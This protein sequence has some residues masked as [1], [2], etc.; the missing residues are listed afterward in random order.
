MVYFHVSLSPCR[1]TSQRYVRSDWGYLCHDPDNL[2]RTGLRRVKWS[3]NAPF[4]SFVSFCF[5][6][7]FN[8]CFCFCICKNWDI[9][10][11]EKHDCVPN[12][13]TQS[14]LIWCTWGYNNTGI[15]IDCH[16][17]NTYCEIYIINA[18][19]LLQKHAFGLS[20][21]IHPHS[22]SL[23]KWYHVDPIVF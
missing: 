21:A 4:P 12:L 18:A 3:W 17:S 23:H 8:G 2:W 10:S 22:I 11:K 20:A 5:P 15:F 13:N 14:S 9:L 7:V 16:L 19:F 6:F 1:L